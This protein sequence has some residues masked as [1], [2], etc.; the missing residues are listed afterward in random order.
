MSDALLEADGLSLSFGGLRAVSDFSLRLAQGDL[1]GLIGPNGAG[2]TTVFNL[3]TG[4]YKPQS[5][6]IRLAGQSLSGLKPFQIAHAGMARTFQNIRLFGHLSVLGVAVQR[7][8]HIGLPDEAGETGVQLLE[9]GPLR[10]DRWK[11]GEVE[12]TL[13][14]EVLQLHDRVAAQADDRV[15]LYPLTPWSRTWSTTHY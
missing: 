15:P 4:V 11:V 3:L 1:Q 2:K 10:P 12:L 14:L 8:L 5:G 13:V 9:A 7:P 6:V